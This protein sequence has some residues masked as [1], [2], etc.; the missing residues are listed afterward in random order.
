MHNHMYKLMAI[1]ECIAAWQDFN[2]KLVCNQLAADYMQLAFN[3]A[4]SVCGHPNASVCVIPW[5]VLIELDLIIS[6]EPLCDFTQELPLHI[7]PPH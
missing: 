2:V 7:C 5:S 4:C 3:R 1:P 6:F